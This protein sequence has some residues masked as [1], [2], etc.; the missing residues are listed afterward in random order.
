MLKANSP[1]L[2]S[3]LGGA[4][5]GSEED[6]EW[7]KELADLNIDPSVVPVGVGGEVERS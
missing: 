7:Q 3:A 5:T 6:E 1:L 4:N 2:I